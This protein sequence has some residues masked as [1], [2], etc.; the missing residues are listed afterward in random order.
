[1]GRIGLYL[2]LVAGFVGP[3][4]LSSGPP[5]SDE[6]APGL[7]TPAFAVEAARRHLQALSGSG[8][9]ETGSAE[10]LVSANYVA[11]VFA[12]AHLQPL[13]AGD[14]RLL[15][16]GPLNRA[17]DARL[18]QIDDDT[19]LIRDPGLI[20][21]DGR[22]S[23]GLVREGVVVLSAA[24]TTSMVLAAVAARGVKAV[25]LPRLPPSRVAR[26]AIPGLLIVGV[27]SAR[28]PELWL[29]PRSP[30]GIELQVEVAASFDPASP[31]VGVAGL[32]PG[33]H[34]RL[35]NELVVIGG[36]LDR[37]ADD[38]AAIV[39]TAALVEAARVLAERADRGPGPERS[40]LIV[41]WSGSLQGGTGLRAWADHPGWAR[42]SIVRVLTVGSPTPR[43]L[44]SR[45]YRVDSVQPAAAPDA[46][47][48]QDAAPG[49]RRAAG[50]EAAAGPDSA[51][52]PDPQAVRRLAHRILSLVA[53]DIG[54]PVGPLPE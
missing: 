31:V 49:V 39:S 28:V 43:V 7:S 26:E 48:G 25:I 44:T 18:L 23:R 32:I 34:P 19:L 41:F 12:R 36:R 13:A 22:S 4:C 35:R 38:P 10:V 29:S 9:V 52:E 16:F 40:V 15:A 46:A 53:G 33:R 5:V 11:E 3:G 50:V 24:D 8:A 1:M 20:R 27:D 54:L 14:Y 6:D 45:G 37:D 17:T 47:A 2:V 51:F 42:D 21:A 30:D